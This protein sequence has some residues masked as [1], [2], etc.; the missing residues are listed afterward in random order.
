MVA[1]FPISFFDFFPSPFHFPS[2]TGFLFS[3]SISYFIYLNPQLS[4]W[5]GS[6]KWLSYLSE[7][8]LLIE[9]AS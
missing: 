7:D 5:K 2:G 1:S 3:Y 9:N 4:I 8:F 6:D